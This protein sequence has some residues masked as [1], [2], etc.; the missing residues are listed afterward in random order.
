MSPRIAL[1]AAGMLLSPLAFAADAV[2]VNDVSLEVEALQTLRGLSLT[3]AQ[4]KALAVLAKEV[5]PKARERKAGKA[6][7][8]YRA[9]L[10]ELR[11][12]LRQNDADKIDTLTE[13]RDD[14]RD[15]EKP[16]LDD[17]VE[18]TDA[19]KRKA[20]EALRLLT[21]KQVIDHVGTYE[22]V[23]D[24]LNLVKTALKDGLDLDDK[25]WKESRDE[26]ATDVGWLL[27]GFDDAK[28]GAIAKRVSA[29]LDKAHAWK[30]V[31]LTKRQGDIEKA[32]QEI[33]GEVGPTDVLRNLLQRDLAELL[34]NPQLVNAIEARL[35]DEK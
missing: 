8:K 33:R 30:G 20:P 23:P 1:V 10:T 3:P 16:D 5:A 7:E 31:E 21:A 26:T 28:A 11:D 2:N 9:A 18:A 15:A 19:A 22:E 25:E 6:S 24:P 35:K 4:L 12:A 14:L 29:L 32:V 34:S 13:K 17:D 27:A